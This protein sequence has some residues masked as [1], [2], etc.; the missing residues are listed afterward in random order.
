MGTSGLNADF[1]RAVPVNHLADNLFA[2]LTSPAVPGARQL[3]GI[4][5]S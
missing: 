4:D 5:R 3:L 2:T 1:D